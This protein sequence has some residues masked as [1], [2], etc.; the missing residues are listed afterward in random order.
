MKPQIYYYCLD[1]PPEQE[2]AIEVSLRKLQELMKYPPLEVDC[3][4]AILPANIRKKIAKDLSHQKF[5]DCANQMYCTLGEEASKDRPPPRLLICC[6]HDHCL[7][8]KCR[9]ASPTA[10]WGLANWDPYAHF[11]NL[12]VAYKL[13]SECAIWHELLHILGADDCYDM[14][15]PDANPGPT[16]EHDQCIMQYAATTA[17]VNGRL[18]LCNENAKLIRKLF[19]KFKD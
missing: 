14:R 1:L 19:A 2:A 11:A 4:I 7:A 15:D 3:E 13:D 16:C 9:D 18:P 6:N 10:K 5:K 8:K 17:I 12:A